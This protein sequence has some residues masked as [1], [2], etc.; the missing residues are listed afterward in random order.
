MHNCSEIKERLTELVLDGG[1][2]AELNTCAECRAEFDSLNATLRMATRVSETAAPAESY[3]SGYHAR[4]REKLAVIGPTASH[5]GP[6]RRGEKLGPLFATMRTCVRMS[7]PVPL[8][9]ALAVIIACLSLGVF[10]FRR[11]EQL[12]AQPTAQPPV[13]V[14]VPVEVPVVQE[15]VITRVVYR[16][17]RSPSGNSRRAINDARVESTFA[18]SRKPVSEEVPASLTGFKPTDEIKLVVIK[19]GAPK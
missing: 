2:A 11:A 16:D 5:A 8:P 14:H 12:P 18:K 17:R 15:K 7:I 10:A 19:G 4:L 6:Q 3:W 13:L 1:S 9:L